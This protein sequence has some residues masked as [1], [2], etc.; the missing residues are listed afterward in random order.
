MTKPVNIK[1]PT[2][3]LELGYMIGQEIMTLRQIVEALGKDSQELKTIKITVPA[4]DE[5]YRQ[6]ST[7]IAGTVAIPDEF[8]NSVCVLVD[9]GTNSVSLIKIADSFDTFLTY[10]PQAIYLTKLYSFDNSNPVDS[11]VA[12]PIQTDLAKVEKQLADREA[13]EREKQKA[14]QDKQ[15]SDII[16]AHLARI[17]ADKYLSEAR[18]LLAHDSSDFADNARSVGATFYVNRNGLSDFLEQPLIVNTNSFTLNNFVSNRDKITALFEKAK[19][20]VEAEY[21]DIRDGLV[22]SF[23]SYTFEDYTTLQF[24][25]L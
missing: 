19:E 11:F 3:S 20:A 23:K 22:Q 9:T 21:R 8:K 1:N 7:Y 15:R 12:T 10:E 24:D 17:V 18:E 13:K 14:E 6:L 16:Y 2:T 5:K 4:Q 25:Y